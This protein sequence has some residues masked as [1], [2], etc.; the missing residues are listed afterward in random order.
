VWPRRL[1]T[2]GSLARLYPSTLSLLLWLL[3]GSWSWGCVVHSFFPGKF[4]LPRQR[5]PSNVAHRAAL[6]CDWISLARRAEG[7]EVST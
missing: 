7:S 6:A 4:I 3:R 2:T 1:G 5:V